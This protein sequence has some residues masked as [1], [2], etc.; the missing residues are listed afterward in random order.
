MRENVMYT[1]MGYIVFAIVFFPLLVF[2]HALWVGVVVLITIIGSI[3]FGQCVKV[4]V[5]SY[6]RKHK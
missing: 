6:R 3:L 2:K 4:M 5:R 1:V